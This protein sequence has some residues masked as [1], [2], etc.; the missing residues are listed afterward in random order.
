MLFVEPGELVKELARTDE[1]HGRYYSELLQ[2][3]QKDV[4][5]RQHTDLFKYVLADYIQASTIQAVLA[6]LLERGKVGIYSVGTGGL[7]PR[8]EL[9]RANATTI[10]TR[11]FYEGGNLI[12]FQSVCVAN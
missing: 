6:D 5:L 4:P 9:K 12:F 3:V 2:L 1:G 8:A 10:R 11:S 7:L